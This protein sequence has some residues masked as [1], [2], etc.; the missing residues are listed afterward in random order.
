MT[1]SESYVPM[2]TGLP[3]DWPQVGRH[4]IALAPSPERNFPCSYTVD[5]QVSTRSVR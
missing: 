3:F 2:M 5:I 4:G 1:N